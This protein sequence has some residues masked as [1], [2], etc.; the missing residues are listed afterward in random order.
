MALAKIGRKPDGDSCRRAQPLP[1]LRRD[2]RRNPDAEDEAKDNAKVE[3]EG[4][5]KD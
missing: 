4:K 2:S 3:V 5:A 1:N